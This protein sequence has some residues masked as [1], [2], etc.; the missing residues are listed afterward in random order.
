MD[1]HPRPSTI[2]RLFARTLVVG[3]LALAFS[4][5]IGAGSDRVFDRAWYRDHLPDEVVALY[6]Y[7]G[8]VLPLPAGVPV[9]VCSRGE[10]VLSGGPDA[11]DGS[12]VWDFCIVH[13]GDSYLMYY[14]GTT[15]GESAAIGMA[16]SDDG[17]RWKKGK[18]N[19]IL[20]EPRGAF[21]PHV[22]YDERDSV[23]RM[24]YGA[25][26]HTYLALS[27][28]GIRWS[29]SGEEP[30]IRNVIHPTVLVESGVYHFYGVTYRN[31]MYEER[32]YLTSR[33][34]ARFREE[35]APVIE[36]S[37]H[38]FFN[39]S[40]HR[41]AGRY[42]LFGN[43]ASRLYHFTADSPAGPWRNEKRLA[44]RD[45]SMARWDL[46]RLAPFVVDLGDRR[47]VYYIG[48]SRIDAISIGAMETM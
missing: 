11:W 16:F 6:K 19:P 14:T 43:G 34:G 22:V 42:H 38:R 2:R 23:Y 26:G 1:T 18:E 15:G 39:P 37:D 32:V 27:A 10:T 31:K 12:S 17:W 7:R 47:R 45:E 28:D 46:M 25:G 30:V 24:Y 21:D 40:L 9:E 48:W 44:V 4:V 35:S 20:T 13:R 36:K 33:D 3:G 29:R 41:Y 8:A 5:M